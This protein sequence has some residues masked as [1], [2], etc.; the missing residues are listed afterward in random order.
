VNGIYLNLAQMAFMIPISQGT[1][2]A[3]G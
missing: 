1:L 3:F 2:F